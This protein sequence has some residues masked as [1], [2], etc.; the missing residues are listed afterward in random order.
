[1]LAVIPLVTAMLFASMSPVTV[2]F[3]NVVS[4]ALEVVVD[5][6]VQFLLFGLEKHEQVLLRIEQS[7]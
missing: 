2:T 4:P 5:E 6:R 3:P 1:V 7:F